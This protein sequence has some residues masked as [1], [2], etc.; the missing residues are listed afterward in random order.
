MSSFEFWI[1]CGPGH[2]DTSEPRLPQGAKYQHPPCPAAWL[3]LLRHRLHS[4]L[5]APSRSRSRFNP[6]PHLEQKNLEQRL[7]NS[8]ALRATPSAAHPCHPPS[9][10]SGLPRAVQGALPGS[11]KHVSIFVPRSLERRRDSQDQHKHADRFEPLQH[12][13]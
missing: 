3:L 8:R 10:R 6:C 2:T 13:V 5:P 11:L 1:S 4:F 12:P 7:S 9:P